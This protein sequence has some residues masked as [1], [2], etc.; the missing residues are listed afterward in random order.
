MDAPCALVL[1]TLLMVS[2]SLSASVS[3][4]SNVV[5]ETLVPLVPP[6]RVMVSATATGAMLTVKAGLR[7]FVLPIRL[8]L[9][10]YWAVIECVP[11]DKDEVL[12]LATPLV[13]ATGAPKAEPSTTNCTLPVGTAGLGASVVI[14]EVR[15]TGLPVATG[16]GD[17][18]TTFVE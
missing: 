4:A 6:C 13:R 9:P 10:A 5:T 1:V 11:W 17:A 2:V 8:V 7:L 3:L 16:L 18:V 15:V 14:V 12:V